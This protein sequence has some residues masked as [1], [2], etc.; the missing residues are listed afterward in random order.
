MKFWDRLGLFVLMLVLIISTISTTIAAQNAA[1]AAKNSDFL[2]NCFTPKTS[3]SNLLAQTNLR[4]TAENKCVIDALINFPAPTERKAK[5]EEILQNYDTCVENEIR[6]LK[7]QQKT[8]TITKAT[9][10]TISTEPK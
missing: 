10:P 1:S 7:S 4:T 5:R 2:A 6:I 8:D 9:I 3:C